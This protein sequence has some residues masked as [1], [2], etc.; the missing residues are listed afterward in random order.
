MLP[1]QIQHCFFECS[2]FLSDAVAGS[3]KGVNTLP[4]SST[5]SLLANDI[6]CTVI[7]CQFI[8]IFYETKTNSW[9]FW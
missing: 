6:V 4:T 5:S 9:S 2:P 7:M 1:Y 3:A 8:L